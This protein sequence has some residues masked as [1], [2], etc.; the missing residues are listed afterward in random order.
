[1]KGLSL[2][3]QLRDNNEENEPTHPGSWPRISVGWEWWAA[4][5]TLL[6][7][8]AAAPDLDIWGAAGGP[9]GGPLVWWAGRGLLS[10]TG[11]ACPAAQTSCVPVPGSP[12]VCQRKPEFNALST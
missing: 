11:P 8:A 7:S 6:K 9:A 10:G 12:A 1:M 2:T 5:E 4:V 3:L